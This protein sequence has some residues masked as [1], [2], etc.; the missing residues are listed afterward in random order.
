VKETQFKKEGISTTTGEEGSPR[1]LLLNYVR[2]AII[3]SW[4]M[5]ALEER[6]TKEFENPVR[7][8]ALEEGAPSLVCQEGAQRFPI[9]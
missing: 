5:L 1:R 3:Y 4:A 2:N 8:G 7:V 9:M 6:S